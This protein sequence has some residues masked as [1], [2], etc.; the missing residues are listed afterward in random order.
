MR[1]FFLF[2]LLVLFSNA[3]FAQL[4]DV[5]K[6]Q[7]SELEDSLKNISFRVFYSK[8]EANRFEANKQ[9]LALWSLILKDEKSMEYPFDSLKKDVSILLAPDKKFRIITWDMRKDDQSYFYFGYIQVNTT[10][11]TKK[12]VLKKEKITQYEVF[13][14]LDKSSSVKTPENYIADPSKWFGMLYVDVVKSDDEFYTLIGWDGNEKLI[15]RKFIDILSFKEDGTP[16]FGKDVFKFPTKF[17]KRIMFQYAG[18]VSMSLKYNSNRKQIIFSHLAPNTP[19]P[20]LE[21]QF[22]YYGPDGSFDAL[23]MKKGKWVYEPAIDIRKD[24]DKNDNA[25]KPEPN[26]QTPIYKPK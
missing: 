8:K 6:K 2:S 21:N 23:E 9:F 24:K 22:Q 15:Q 7:F 12:G 11:T 4:T 3:V 26:N 1:I 14:L 25:K 17:A 13:P 19:D 16:I 5:E 20:T 18:E 10:K